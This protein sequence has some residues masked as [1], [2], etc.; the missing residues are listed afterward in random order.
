[1]FTQLEL[2]T[3]QAAEILNVSHAYLIK[4]L[5][6]GRILYRESGSQQIILTQSLLKYK[7]VEEEKANRALEEI[8]FISEKL[9]LY[10]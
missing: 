2:T 4:L 6:Q 5:K 8:V 10:D 3:H 7:A 1:M 9:G